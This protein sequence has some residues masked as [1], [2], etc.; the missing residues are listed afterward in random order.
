MLTFGIEILFFVILKDTQGII[1][2]IYVQV[3]ET[4][5]DQLNNIHHSSVLCLIGLSD[6]TFHQEIMS[7]GEKF[8]IILHQI[9]KVWLWLSVYYC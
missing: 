2:P 5:Y 6:A 8:C 9:R 4:A 7:V 3:T 1:K